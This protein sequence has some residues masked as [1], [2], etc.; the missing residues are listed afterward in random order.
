MDLKKE[1]AFKI[2]ERFWS[3]PDA[4]KAKDTFENLFQKKNFESAQTVECK[5]LS[6]TESLW[7]IDLLK[8]L[9]AVESSSAARRL[10]KDGAVTVNG[11]KIKDFHENVLLKA[12]TTIKVGKHKFYRLV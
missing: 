10:V 5:G 11:S 9:N 4:E 8:R 2:V 3:K 1:L 12:G 7:I 6:E